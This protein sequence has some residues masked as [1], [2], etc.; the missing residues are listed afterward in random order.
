MTTLEISTLEAALQHRFERPALLQ[1]ALT[2]SSHAHEAIDASS[3]SEHS[4]AEPAGQKISHS[5]GDN[6]ILEFLGDAVLGFVTSEALFA[7]FPGKHEGELSKMRA[8]LVSARHLVRVAKQLDLGNYIRLGRGEEKSGGRSKAAILVDAL[9]AVIAALYLDGGL[10]LARQFIYREIVSP[11]LERMQQAGEAVPLTDYK[12]A[13]QESVQSLGQ[14]QPV[15][16]IANET[17]PDHKKIFTAEVRLH[18]RTGDQSPHLVA[19]AEGHSKKSAE[20]RAARQAL[21]RLGKD[22][23]RPQPGE[24]K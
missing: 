7:T 18:L 22:K 2:H 9:E 5:A 12:S 15:Y 20:Q 19:R 16:L 11:E 23:D 21:E 10:E 4:D 1:Q 17:G 8:H 6:E 24:A 13:L 14:P 3:S